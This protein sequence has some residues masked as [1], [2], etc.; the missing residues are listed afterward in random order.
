MTPALPEALARA[1][2]WAHPAWMLGWLV[3]AAT[4][5]R[6]GLRM[7]RA[8]RAGERRPPELRRRHLR[9]ARPAVLALLAGFAAGPVSAVALRGFGAFESFHGFAGLAAATLFAAAGWLGHRIARGRSR[10][11]EAHGLLGALALLGAALAAVAG[12]SLLP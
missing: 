8:R 3:V 10:A 4:A 11:V 1:L 9:L 12:L 5:L 2:A 7:R 6:L